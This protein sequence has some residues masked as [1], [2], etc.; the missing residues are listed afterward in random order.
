M[1]SDLATSGALLGVLAISVSFGSAVAAQATVVD[2]PASQQVLRAVQRPPGSNIIKFDDACPIDMPALA[3][4]SDDTV[5]LDVRSDRVRESAWIPGAV[6]IS[7]PQIA[8]STLV[9]SAHRVALIGDSRHFERL[10]RFCSEQR[11]QGLSNL[12][13]LTGGFPAWVRG[14]GAVAGDTA[15]ALAPQMLDSRALHEL[16][17][18]QRTSLIFVGAAPADEMSKL[19]LP[20]TRA[21]LNQSPRNVLGKLSNSKNARSSTVIFIPD[22]QRVETWRAAAQAL[23]LPEPLFFVGEMTRY[24][25]YL[26]QQISIA[27]GVSENSSSL[28]EPD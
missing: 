22:Q 11:K 10:V 14:G 12:R 17:G 21:H 13:V 2:K 24:D 8:S 16:L 18:Y 20:I 1:R 15:T 7:L 28:C 9:Q 3:E 25:A 4:K 6:Q 5:L 27:E 23:G 26:A 19:G